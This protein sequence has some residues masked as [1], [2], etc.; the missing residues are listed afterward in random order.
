MPIVALILGLAL[1]TSDFGEGERK[2]ISLIPA[3]RT[4]W[5][6]GE[7]RADMWGLLK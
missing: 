5:L 2:C 6:E 4:R 7:R 3:S 1:Y